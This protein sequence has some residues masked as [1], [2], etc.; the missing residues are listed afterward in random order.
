M[1]ARWNSS[2]APEKTRTFYARKR[3]AQLL[4][5]HQDFKHLIVARAA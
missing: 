1:V 2:R 3:L 4:S 5:I